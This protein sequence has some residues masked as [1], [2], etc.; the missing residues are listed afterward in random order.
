MFLPNP[1]VYRNPQ[2]WR[3]DP[4]WRSSIK[5]LQI[6]IESAFLMAMGGDGESRPRAASIPNALAVDR[7]GGARGRDRIADFVLRRVGARRPLFPRGALTL[8]N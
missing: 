5:L 4:P 2:F 7:H 8:R 1:G 3:P 6:V